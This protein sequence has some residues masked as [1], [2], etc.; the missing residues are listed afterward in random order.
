[1]GQAK[2]QGGKVGNGEHLVLAVEVREAIADLRWCDSLVLVY[3]T[4]WF[5]FPAAMKGFFDRVMLPGVAFK[6]PPKGN[7]AGAG[8]TGLLPGFTNISKIGVVT[9]YGAYE[10][11]ALYAGDNSRRFLSRAFRP[12]CAPNC[13]L[14]WHGLYSMDAQSLAQRETFLEKVR[15]EYKTF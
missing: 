9:T 4:W 14:L 11:A 10:A 3:P 5:N 8:T 7:K 6:I 13:H 12:L 2:G 15:E 1:M